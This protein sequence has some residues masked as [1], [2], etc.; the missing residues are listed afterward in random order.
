MN[1]NL[2]NI[3]IFGIVPV[4]NFNVITNVVFHLTNKNITVTKNALLMYNTDDSRFYPIYC[5]IY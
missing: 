3:R 2:I 1:R 5:S 4:Y